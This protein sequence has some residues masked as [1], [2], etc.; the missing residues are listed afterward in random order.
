MRHTMKTGFTLVSVVAADAGS[1][2]QAPATELRRIHNRRRI[3]P[4][5]ARS[6]GDG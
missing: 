3:L 2:R 5:R 1:V 6:G 4:L